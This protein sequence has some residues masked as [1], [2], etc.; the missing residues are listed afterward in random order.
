MFERYKKSFLCITIIA[1]MT[2][3]LC[4]MCKVYYDRFQKAQFESAINFKQ[5]E[6]VLLSF[7]RASTLSIYKTLGVNKFRTQT[8]PK[9]VNQSMY[10]GQY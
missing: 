4:T 6:K 5:H 2:A 9:Y 8:S 10:R 7:T 3:T 1:K